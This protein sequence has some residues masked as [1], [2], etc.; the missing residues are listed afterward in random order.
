MPAKMSLL[1]MLLVLAV[2][3]P[4]ATNATEKVSG[5]Y[6]PNLTFDQTIQVVAKVR[7]GM[8]QR[9][10]LELL[11]TNGLHKVG[12]VLGDNFVWGF[13]FNLSEDYQLCLSCGTT[14]KNVDQGH[15]NGIVDH[16]YI[17]DRKGA[18]IFEIT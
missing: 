11:E 14:L 6:V 9:Q 2:D 4:V 8:P 16:I 7:I 3:W 1:G 15:A 17:E 18:V 13:F 10:A 5:D 12:A